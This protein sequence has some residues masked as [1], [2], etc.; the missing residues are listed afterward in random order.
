MGQTTCSIDRRRKSTPTWCDGLR[1]VEHDF[2]TVFSWNVP[3]IRYQIPFS[4]LVLY[5]CLY[6]VL[7]FCVHLFCLYFYQTICTILL[8]DMLQCPIYVYSDVKYIIYS[9]FILAIILFD[10]FDDDLFQFVVVE[11]NRNENIARIFPSTTCNINSFSR[12]YS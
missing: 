2:L 4:C 10:S 11:I 9:C 6:V 1:T 5:F 12:Q 3:L 8:L 7:G